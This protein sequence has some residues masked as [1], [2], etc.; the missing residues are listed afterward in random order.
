M[1]KSEKKSERPEKPHSEVFDDASLT[2][3]IIL[4]RERGA[5]LSQVADLLKVPDE[6]VRTLYDLAMQA[7]W[8]EPKEMQRELELRRLDHVQMAHWENCIKGDTK[9]AQVVFRCIELRMRLTGID[10]PVISAPTSSGPVTI[11]IARH[12]S[13]PE[14]SK[15]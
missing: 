11:M 7:V 4:L 8:R 15:T 14:P 13:V 1:S 2:K 10:Q 9:A 3:R 12:P 5:T 6:R